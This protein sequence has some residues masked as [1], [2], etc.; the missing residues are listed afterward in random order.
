M[1]PHLNTVG[2]VSLEAQISTGLGTI[3]TLLHWKQVLV[4]PTHW[5]TGL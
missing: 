1:A 4:V 5:V 3:S 2:P